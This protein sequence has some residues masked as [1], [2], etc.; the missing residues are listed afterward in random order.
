MHIGPDLRTPMTTS[1]RSRRHARHRV[2]VFVKVFT[3]SGETLEGVSNDVSERGMTLYVSRR[4][5]IG[6]QVRVEFRIPTSL[7]YVNLDALVRDC[8]GFRCGVEFHDLDATHERVL[9]KSCEEL[10]ALLSVP[11][12]A[13]SA[14]A[15]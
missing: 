2:R 1:E 6:Q 15:L 5:E 12:S 8:N 10:T 11:S 7:E 14:N 9:R 3:L 13:Q 4:F